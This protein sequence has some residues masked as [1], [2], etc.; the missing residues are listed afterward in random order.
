[1]AVLTVRNLPDEVHRALR[2]RAAGNRRS[3]E[4][5]VREILASAVIP[6]QRIRMGTAMA[7]ITRGN[8]LTK[9]DVFALEKAIKETRDNKPAEPLRFE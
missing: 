8:G 5:E 2:L 1:M 9:E 7:A 3:T 4:S 6:E